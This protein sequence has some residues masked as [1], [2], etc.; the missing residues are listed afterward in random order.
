[1]NTRTTEAEATPTAQP[2]AASRRSNIDG[3]IDAL[4]EVLIALSEGRDPVRLSVASFIGPSQDFA[5]K[6][7]SCA[8][9]SPS[10][11][12]TSRSLTRRISGRL[13]P[14]TSR[15]TTCYASTPLMTPHGGAC[16]WPF[17]AASSTTS[18]PSRT[19]SLSRPWVS[20][21][22]M[23]LRHADMK[24]IAALTRLFNAILRLGYF[25]QAWKEGLVVMLPKAR[26][27]PRNP[28]SYRP[29][30][31]LSAVSK[32]FERLIIPLL[33]LHISPREEQHGFRSGH[34]TTLQVARVVNHT[35]NILNWKESAVAAFLD[36]SRAFDRVWHP[37]LLHKLLLADTPHHIASI[38]A[39]FLR[40]RTVRVRVES[41]YSSSHPIAAGVPQG[42]SLST[43]LYSLYT[44]GIP[45]QQD[46]LLA[47][48]ADDIA[49]VTKSLSPALLTALARPRPAAGL[50]GG[51][52]ARAQ[53]R[54]DPTH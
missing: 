52:E 34:S 27:S 21:L 9:Y 50:A 15:A 18:C 5:A 22:N 41:A 47:L 7:R 53:C 28:D 11:P 49:L 35:A 29:I 1:M 44:N 40:G 17:A 19:P 12:P 6:Y 4:E 54:Q 25:P 31:L 42:S 37:G 20:K 38:L 10:T 46:T 26:K 14:R 3:A 16:L 43:A 45:V 8:T 24:T 39:S 2:T 32:L 33:L 13:T 23:A 48:Y 36:V 51:V 30:T